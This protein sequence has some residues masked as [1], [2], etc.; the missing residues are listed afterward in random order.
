MKTNLNLHL[1]LSIFFLPLM[2]M[3]AITGAMYMAGT[4]GQLGSKVEVYSLKTAKAS[5]EALAELGQLGVVLPEGELRAGKGGKVMLGNGAARHISFSTGKDGQLKAEVTE[6]GLY[7]RLMLIHKGKAGLWFT[8]LGY[9][10][11]ACM[12]LLYVTGIAILWRNRRKRALMLASFGLGCVAV[13]L[14]FLTL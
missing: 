12:L 6:P 14:G 1:V 5:P 4:D 7:P 10:A 3:Y 2:L 11:A 13:L 9:G 8:V